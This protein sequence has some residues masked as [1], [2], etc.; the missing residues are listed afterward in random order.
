MGY[1]FDH[2][3]S[4]KSIKYFHLHVLLMQIHRHLKCFINS[5]EYKMYGVFHTSLSFC[6]KTKNNYMQHSQRLIVTCTN[7]YFTLEDA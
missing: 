2:P 4:L 6:K 7:N 3:F 1:L 5:H